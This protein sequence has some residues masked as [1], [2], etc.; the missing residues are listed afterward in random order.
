MKKFFIYLLITMTG[1]VAQNA[2]AQGSLV[3]ENGLSGSKLTSDL[4]TEYLTNICGAVTTTSF[5][6]TTTTEITG[7]PQGKAGDVYFVDVNNFWKGG[8]ESSAGVAT[9]IESGVKKITKVNTDSKHTTNTGTFYTHPATKANKFFFIVRRQARRSGSS[10]DTRAFS[11]YDEWSYVTPDENGDYISGTSAYD[12]LEATWTKLQDGDPFPS[13]HNCQSSLRTNHYIALKG[14]NPTEQN[15]ITGEWQ[16]VTGYNFTAYLYVPTTEPTY[17]KSRTY[18]ITNNSRYYSTNSLVTV[19][20]NVNGEYKTIAEAYPNMYYSTRSIDGVTGVQG[21]TLEDEVT[22]TDNIPYVFFYAVKLNEGVLD[23]NTKTEGYDATKQNKYKVN[24]DW[25]TAFNRHKGFDASK[26]TTYEGMQEHYLVERSYNNSDWETVTDQIIVTENGITETTGKTTEDTKLKP[27]NELTEQIGYTVWYRVTSYVEKS[28]GTRMSATTSNVVS[29]DIPGKVPFKLAI[30]GEGHSSF[31]PVAGKNK[32][33]NT[34]VSAESKVTDAEKVT[35]E[36]GSVLALHTVNADNTLG[37]VLYSVTATTASDFVTL[38]DL[39]NRIDN[40]EDGVYNGHY[41][42]VAVLDAG[43]GIT[44]AY[45]LV[46]TMPSGTKKTSN[47]L[48]ISNPAI[49]NSTVK[50]H[51]SGTPDVATCAESETFHNEVKFK[52]SANQ[53]GSGYYIYRDASETNKAPKVTLSYTEEGFLDS[54]TGTYYKPGN[55]GYISVVDIMEG[56]PIAVDE[57]GSA[58]NDKTGTWQYAVAHYDA[59]GNTY[60][61]QSVPAA[62]NGAHDELVLTVTPEIK[63]ANFSQPGNYNIYTVVTINWSRRFDMADTQPSKFEIYMKKKGT[64]VATPAAESAAAPMDME[65]GFVKIADVTADDSNKNGGTYTYDETYLSKWQ[66]DKK[67]KYTKDELAKSLVGEYEV[68]V[69]MTTT[70]G[71]KKN[72]YTASP[73]PDAG[74]NI[75]TGIE[76]VEAQEMDVKV[77]NGVVEV[78]GVYGM[79]KVIDATGAVAAEA[80]GTGDVT[81]IEGLGTGVYVVTAKD[82]KPTKILIK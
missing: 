19:L 65:A 82:M 9:Q 5:W 68:Y 23:D 38:Q 72:S 3:T 73:I 31:D 53:I 35:L 57:T 18:Y 70:E 2:W 29:V 11:W 40:T 54:E 39:A 51:R 69:K 50:V 6:G 22:V 49:S 80:V 27:F 4:L 59:K 71:K 76:G 42:D 47:I 43:D 1:L 79:I 48:R 30:L 62:Y 12:K 32:F 66:S 15:P 60:G 67:T 8:A 24:L 21:Y 14:K 52:A 25:L 17:N 26:N 16:E 74:A 45:Q 33:T 61:S 28:D 44:A 37:D 41:D 20:V 46:L 81:E 7:V 77:V 55:D 56:D 64:D 36:D 34:I 63:A 13:P 78:N 10:Y 58:T 75:Y